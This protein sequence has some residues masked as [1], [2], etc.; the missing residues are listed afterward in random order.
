MK[1]SDNN[2]MFSL[3]EGVDKAVV[4][5]IWLEGTD[6]ACTDALRASDYA[7]R[8]RFTGTD[9]EGNTFSAQ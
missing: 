1:L 7:I 4:V 3:K 9:M 5:H 2:A 8:L 6:P